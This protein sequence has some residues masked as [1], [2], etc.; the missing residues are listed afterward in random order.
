MAEELL[1]E[2]LLT[3]VELLPGVKNEDL[4]KGDPN[5]K[6]EYGDC[7]L[8]GDEPCPDMLDLEAL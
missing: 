2:V 3:R 7:L 4:P 5:G 1:A 6:G 8:G